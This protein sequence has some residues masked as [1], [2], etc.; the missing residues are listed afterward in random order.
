MFISSSYRVMFFILY[1][2]KSKQANREHINPAGKHTHYIFFHISSSESM[3]T[4]SV[5]L[6][7]KTRITILIN[8]SRNLCYCN[9]RIQ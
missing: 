5:L 2:Q 9:I 4:T 6:Y 8:T 7:G 3:E 1:G